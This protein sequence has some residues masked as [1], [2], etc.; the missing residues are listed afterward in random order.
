MNISF[1]NK[2]TTVLFLKLNFIHG[3]KSLEFRVKRI[4]TMYLEKI[5]ITN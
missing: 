2:L 5:R 4:R 1:Y 3:V